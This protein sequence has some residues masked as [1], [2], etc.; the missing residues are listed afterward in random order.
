MSFILHRV[1]FCG[2]GRVVLTSRVLS[3][4]VKKKQNQIMLKHKFTIYFIN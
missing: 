1:T 4:N 3:Q 2:R